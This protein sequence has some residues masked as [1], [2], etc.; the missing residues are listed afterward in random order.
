MNILDIKQLIPNSQEWVSAEEIRYGWSGEQKY[1][2]TDNKK[3]K[4]LL[5]LLNREQ[6]NSQLHAIKFLQQC[7][8]SINNIPKVYSFGAT[9]DDNYSYLLLDYIIGKNGMEVIRDYDTDNQYLLGYKMG[10]TLFD[11]HNL[12]THANEY[13]ESCNYEHEVEK[14]LNYYSINKEKF[15][16][17]TNVEKLIDNLMPV[18]SNRAKV[19][20]HNDFHL[21]NMIINNDEI[22]LIDFNR[23]KLGDNIKDFDCIAWSAKYSVHFATGLLDAYVQKNPNIDEFFQILRGYINIWQIQM[24]YFIA[25]QDEEEKKIVLDLIKFTSTWFDVDANIPNWYLQNSKILKNKR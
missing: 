11:I 16:F 1:I 22:Y 18:I 19:M 15:P 10:K 21:G 7:G 3:Q 24:L 5:R 23:A 8:C 20:L 6:F 13:S 14:Y 9:N 25:N 2:I 12:N 4:F 17:L